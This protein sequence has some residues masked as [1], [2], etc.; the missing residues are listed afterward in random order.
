M[1]NPWLAIDSATPPQARALELRKAWERFVGNGSEDGVRSPIA[2]SWKRSHAAGVDTSPERAAPC[3]TDSDETAAR[4]AVHPLATVA[5]L[6]RECLDCV[7]D[8]A[9]HLMVISDAQG[10]LLWIEG[11]ARVRL[12][13]AD[14][15][16]FAEGVLWSEGG[17]GTNAIGTALAAD[18]AVQVFAAEHFNEAVQEWTCAAA[19]VHDPD[20][21]EILGIIDLTSRMSTVHP[22]SFAVALSTAQAVEAQLRV[23]LHE[24]DDRLRARYTD[25]LVGGEGRALVGSTGR[26]VDHQPQ[27]W[28]R[29]DRLAVP[30]GGGELT[31]PSGAPAL[32]EPVGHEGAYI[33]RAL[34]PARAA[35]PRP[36]L[37]LRLLGRDRASVTVAGRE[38]PVRRRQSEI[39]ALLCARPAGMTTEELGVDLYGDS[40]NPS[41]VRGEV[42]RLRKRLGAFI[43][44]DP[45]RLKGHVDSDAA[46]IKALL[47]RGEVS[48]AAARYDGP[49]LPHSEAP[50]VVREREALDRWLRH[51]VMTAGDR[52]ALWSWARSA[53]GQDDLAAWKA[54]L[55][56]LDFADPRRSLA[57]ARVGC[58]RKEQGIV[59][60]TR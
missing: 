5:P 13:A 48:E 8:D 52:E 14:A 4:W 39:L 37:E 31:L 47:E 60:V 36:A 11:N 42:S 16:N 50:G 54:V 12:D 43:D 18:H 44:T 51:A 26:V 53:S 9:A 45:Y 1:L 30:A 38:V 19:P 49:L 35:G 40:A 33:V 41:S 46:R 23:R 24:S 7:A 10:L 3:I 21:G 57:A 34:D 27:G 32:A 58:L 22:H 56:R 28:L 29:A 59:P 2:E 55:S 6:I 15:M 25:R 20:T 17:A